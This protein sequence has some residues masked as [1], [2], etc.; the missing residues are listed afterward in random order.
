MSPWALI[1]GG[2]A[3]LVLILGSFNVG[4]V[5]ERA[6]VIE[7]DLKRADKVIVRL[8]TINKVVPKIVT[9]TV[10]REVEV[11]KEVDRVVTASHHMLAPDC[12]LPGDFGLLLVAAANGDD[13]AAPGSAAQYAGGYDC[14]QTLAAILSD[15]RAGWV[16]SA[17]LEGLQQ[18]EKLVAQPTKGE[19]P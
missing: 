10:T 5:Y 3:M 7:A 18:Y 6:G 8:E 9:K 11:V 2:V 16:N 1:G 12:V 17:R 4:R 13:P 15:L 19:K 14:R